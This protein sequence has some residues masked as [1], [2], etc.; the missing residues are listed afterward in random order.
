M[1]YGSQMSEACK[2]QV[3][4]LPFA[5]LPHALVDDR[6]LNGTQ[7]R[8]AAVLCRY[9]RSKAECWPAVATLAT[10]LGLGRR[11]VQLS[12]RAL[13]RAGWIGT[14]PAENPTGRVIFLTW[15]IAPP[16]GDCAPRAQGSAPA[17]APRVAPEGET[18]REKKPPG[19]AAPIGP[20]PAGP[21]RTAA[22]PAP[23]TVEQGRELYAAS[24]ARPH[25]DTLR[26]F[27]EER[28][29]RLARSAAGPL[30]RPAAP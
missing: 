10:A 27:A 12:L 8:L 2:G 26:R 25:G 19:V 3:G 5:A 1:S 28:L 9:A 17:P 14:R 29:R 15:R 6:R 7:V 20:P 22:A 11:S 18:Q 24:L 23:L 21:R 30:P 16:A 13:E 4:R